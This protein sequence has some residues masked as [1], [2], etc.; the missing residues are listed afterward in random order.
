MEK[1]SASLIA[2]LSALFVYLALREICARKPAFW[3]TV[4]YAFGTNTWVISSQ[5][6]WQHGVSELALSLMCYALLRSQTS[7][8]WLR[9]AG[10][11]AGLAAAARP[12]NIILSLLGLMYVWR[13]HRRE[14]VRFL[15]WP[16][17][18]AIPLV[19]YNLFYFGGI[20]GGYGVIELTSSMLLGNFLRLDY[21]GLLGILFSP[22]RG[23]LIYT[24]FVLFSFWGGILL[25]RDRTFAPLLRYMSLGVLSQVFLYGKYSVWWGGWSYGPRL[26]T[27]ICPILCLMLVPVLPLFRRRIVHGVFIIA[28]LLSIAVQIIGAFCYNNGWDAIPVSVDARP[29]R[30]W[31]WHDTQILRA[32]QSGLAPKNLP[33]SLS[34]FRQQLSEPMASRA[35]L[36]TS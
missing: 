34:E 7:D 16:V 31:D 26:L 6:L 13:F 22:S 15:L 10:L 25:W 18:I 11:G 36:P 35:Q 32:L 2:S 21:E 29:Q 17:I 27:D 4:L 23:L 28:S 30:L 33:I 5:A 20:T 3:L 12:T 14:T 19:S 1:L 24:P 9:L 8:S